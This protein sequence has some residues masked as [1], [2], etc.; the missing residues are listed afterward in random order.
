MKCPNCGAE[1]PDGS[2]FCPYCNWKA[3]TSEEEAEKSIRARVAERLK[4]VGGKVKGYGAVGLAVAGTGAYYGA[5]YGGKAARGIAK[6][7]GAAV[8]SPYTLGKKALEQPE[9][10]AKHYWFIVFGALDFYWNASRGISDLGI[11]VDIIIAIFAMSAYRN[12]YI[13]IPAFFEIVY[14]QMA[15]RFG[16]WNVLPA[17]LIFG[18]VMFVKDF[19]RMEMSP[20]QTFMLGFSVFIFLLFFA[21]P[22]L[23][24][25]NLQAAEVKT[26]VIDDVKNFVDDRVDRGTFRWGGFVG[27][28]VDCVVPD[29]M[30]GNNNCTSLQKRID[31]TYTV[32]GKT[33]S[34]LAPVKYEAKFVE[35]LDNSYYIS[36]PVT[37]LASFA[38]EGEEYPIVGAFNWSIDNIPGKTTPSKFATQHDGVMYR[39]PES[40]ISGEWPEGTFTEEGTYEAVFRAEFQVVTQSDYRTWFV[41]YNPRIPT[42]TLYDKYPYLKKNRIPQAEKAPGPVDVLVSLGQKEAPI[43]WRDDGLGYRPRIFIQLRDKNVG[44]KREHLKYL[45]FVEVKAEDWFSLGEESG[46]NDFVL[47]EETGSWKLKKESLERINRRLKDVYDEL[48]ITCPMSI[49]AQELFRNSQTDPA[50]VSVATRVG[51]VYEVRRTKD[52]EIK[53]L[54]KGLNVDLVYCPESEDFARRTLTEENITQ[55]INEEAYKKKIPRIIA[56]SVAKTESQMRQY[57]S[58]NWRTVVGINRNEDGTVSSI[59]YGVM[60]VNWEHN[61]NMGLSQVKL[62]CS[63]EYNIEKGMEILKQ[64]Y[65]RCGKWEPALNAYNA[66]ECY[67]DRDNTARQADGLIWQDKYN[68]Q[69]YSN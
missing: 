50:E 22:A 16:L 58:E 18:I 14:P 21:G 69:V 65:N 4:S 11:I 12:Y 56:L 44:S 17:W 43:I 3:E 62:A 39:Y 8:A 5:K 28:L 35:N 46:C 6:G 68:T 67:W 37:L 38:I 52:I 53:D 30:G 64:A 48:A 49:N 42:E 57:D 61:K 66:G 10:F 24:F 26:P 9:S 15:L 40:I 54:F 51:Y 45:S 59:D 31:P 63:Y 47:N 29:W 60:Q 33:R 25:Q 20:S 41:R 32:P 19:P 1:L 34:D 13:F 55:K 2:T 23:N 36:E 7:A 27:D